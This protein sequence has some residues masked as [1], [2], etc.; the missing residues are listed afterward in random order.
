MA[1]GPM[2]P[3]NEFDRG[4][5]RRWDDG[6]HM[7]ALIFPWMSVIGLVLCQ[8]VPLPRAGLFDQQM[9][10]LQPDRRGVHQIERPPRRQP[11]P[12]DLIRGIPG[13]A[14]IAEILKKKPVVRPGRVAHFRVSRP[15]RA[16]RLRLDSCSSARRISSPRD[17]KARMHTHHI[18]C[19][20]RS[21]AGANVEMLHC[22]APL[23]MSHDNLL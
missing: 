20:S 3:G 18:A 10:W 13:C 22:G 2:R 5:E 21:I 7:L 15:L 17:Q 19:E 1:Q 4:L 6:N 16:P 14:A 12:K 8:G 23:S 9:M 11:D